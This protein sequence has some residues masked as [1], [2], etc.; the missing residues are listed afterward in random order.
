MSSPYTRIDPCRLLLL[1]AVLAAG[2]PATAIAESA[3]GWAAPREEAREAPEGDLVVRVGDIDNL[4]FGWEEGF[5]PFTGRSTAA[6]DF[7]WS[8]D[9]TDPAGT[10]RIMVIS[11]HRG[12][13]GDGYAASTA[14]PENAVQTLDLRFDPGG[15]SVR[16]AALQLFVDDFQAPVW[17][18]RF[19]ATLDGREAPDIAFAL[20]ALNQTGPI[21]K[22]VTLQLLPEYVPLLADGALAIRIDDAGTDAGEGFALDFV[23]LIVNPKPWK[24]TG[25]VSGITQRADDGTPLSGVLVSAG[26][27]RQATTGTDGR[28]TLSGVPAGLVVTVGSHPDYLPDSEVADLEVDGSLDLVLE[29]APAPRSGDALAERLAREGRVDLYGI[30]FD[31]DSATLK[32]ESTATLTEVKA[33]LEA[34]PALR[35]AIAGH[36]D[37]QGD[38]AHNLALSA[39]RAQAVVDWLAGEG[40]DA[41]RLVAEGLGESRPVADNASPAGRAL[42]RRVEIRDASR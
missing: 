37:A 17:G 3:E 39:R 5:D 23:R 34:D 9:A 4:G 29:L 19:T 38:E 41:A 42:N 21:G 16:T 12:A 28:F 32:P 13:E 31:T 14:R 18:H 2:A 15:V 36:T 8:P 35:L 7:P 10:D 27:V 24:Y 30:Y 25:T 6:H 40:I 20:N 1:G 33:L 11:G 26:N 22:L